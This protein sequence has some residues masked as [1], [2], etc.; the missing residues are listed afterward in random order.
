M[1]FLGLIILLVFVFD[2]SKMR[3]QNETVIEQNE[4]II[5]LLEEIKNK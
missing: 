1:G 3:S 5:S 4:K 2:F